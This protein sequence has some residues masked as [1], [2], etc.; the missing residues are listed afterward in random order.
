MRQFLAGLFLFLSSL[1]FV[2]APKAQAFDDE[3]DPKPKAKAKAEG[4]KKDK[5]G[6]KKEDKEK[7]KEL[8]D[9]NKRLKELLKTKPVEARAQISTRL[10]QLPT[11]TSW[12]SSHDVVPKG[13]SYFQSAPGLLPIVG[14]NI[15][16]GR[17]CGCKEVHQGQLTV[18]RGHIGGTV[19]LT[20]N[21]P[22][23][24]LATKGPATV[25]FQPYDGTNLGEMVLLEGAEADKGFWQF[26]AGDV[27]IFYV[28]AITP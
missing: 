14:A 7:I 11:F 4:D 24:G 21:N 18:F 19:V 15:G 12:F 26:S 1:Y 27:G 23:S 13:F 3:D 22:A 25:W 28:S 16:A 8:E 6:E 2:A 5:K 17:V 20:N 10:S 9:E